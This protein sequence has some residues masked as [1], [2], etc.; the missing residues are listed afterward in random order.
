[1]KDH[2]RKDAALVTS[3]FCYGALVSDFAV[4]GTWYLAVPGISEFKFTAAV[5]SYRVFDT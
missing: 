3:Q 5:P 4:Q 2:R 1:M